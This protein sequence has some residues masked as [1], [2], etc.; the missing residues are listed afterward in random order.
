MHTRRVP[1][2][3]LLFA[4]AVSMIGNNF[5]A[6]AIPW[7]VLETTGS[8]ARTGV[9]AVATVLPTVMSA[10]FGGTVADRVGS[11]RVSVVADLVSGVTVAMIPLLHHT[12]GLSFPVL[13]ALVFLGALLDAP[14][15][16]ARM[17][18]IPDLAEAGGVSLARA[19]G[20]S[21]A[22][23][24]GSMFLGPPIAG[25]CIAWLGSRDVLWLDAASFAISAAVFLALVPTV[26]TE[27][28]AGRRYLDD[29]REGLAFIR[30]DRFLVSMLSIGAIANFAGAPLYSVLLPVYARDWRGN[31][32]DLGLLLG[33]VGAGSLIGALAFSSFGTRFPRRRLALSLSFLSAAPV[34]ILALNPPIWLAV[35]AMAISGFGDGSVNPLVITVIYE[36]VP[37]A[38]RGRVIGTLLACILAAAPIG[39]LVIGWSVRPLGID[40][41]ILIVAAILL[42]VTLL[43][44]LAPALRNLDAPEPMESDVPAIDGELIGST[45]EYGPAR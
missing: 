35:A 16:T 1:L 23:Q 27:A 12:I 28:P 19:N 2:I 31:A 43:F 41:V 38:L 14:G 4:N 9:V 44:A 25:A 26:A 32:T 8:A 20:A 24:S 29:V 5:A 42:L 39:M 21:Q 45:P 30:S 36:R 37:A 18:I 10:V 22:I 7:F 11:K 40:L 6:V 33:G 17:A 3:A 34:A 13:V 15:N